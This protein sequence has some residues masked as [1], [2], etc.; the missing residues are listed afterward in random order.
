MPPM[1]GSIGGAAGGSFLGISTIVASVV[2]SKA[3]TEAAFSNATLVTFVGSII[4][5]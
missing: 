3:D 5:A 4:P 2:R 1:Q